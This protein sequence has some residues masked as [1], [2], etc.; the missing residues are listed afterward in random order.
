M[1]RYYVVFDGWAPDGLT[2]T[3]PAAWVTAETPEG[4][5]Q[6]ARKKLGSR[7]H[8]ELSMTTCVP[9]SEEDY[10]KAQTKLM[11]YYKARRCDEWGR[12]PTLN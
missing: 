3:S 12:D 10:Q 8:A 5:E 7:V 11:A 2:V 1:T 9:F 4:A 6:A